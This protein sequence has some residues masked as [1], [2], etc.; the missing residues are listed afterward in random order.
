MVDGMILI[1][2]NEEAGRT[3]REFRIAKTRGAR[4]Y[5]RWMKYFIGKKTIYIETPKDP[6]EFQEFARLVRG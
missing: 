1:R 5:E 6:E 3:V 2:K 4:T